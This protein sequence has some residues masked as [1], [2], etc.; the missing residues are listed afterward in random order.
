MFADTS[1]AIGT[2]AAHQRDNPPAGQPQLLQS[3]LHASGLV[4]RN[5]PCQLFNE[6]LQ[7]CWNCNAAAS[8]VPSAH[9]LRLAHWTGSQNRC[10]SDAQKLPAYPTRQ[11]LAITAGKNRLPH[12]LFPALSYLETQ[13]SAKANT[14]PHSGRR[15]SDAAA[16]SQA[17]TTQPRPHRTAAGQQAH[18]MSKTT[19]RL[20]R[21]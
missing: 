2:A 1:S 8:P 4:G 11:T 3:S 10:T 12:H 5:L 20:L 14:R 13:T 15:G 7:H 21:V 16:A 6:D 19:L 9:P 17:C 18:E